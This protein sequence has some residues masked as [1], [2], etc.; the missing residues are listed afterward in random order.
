MVQ[1]ERARA[2]RDWWKGGRVHCSLDQNSLD[3]KIQSNLKFMQRERSESS[4]KKVDHWLYIDLLHLLFFCLHPSSHLSLAYGSSDALIL[5]TVLIPTWFVIWLVVVLRV[6][7]CKCR[8]LVTGHSRAASG[9]HPPLSGPQLDGTLWGQR[10]LRV[11]VGI[12]TRA[13]WIPPL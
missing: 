4:P 5:L 8:V 11:R 13:E 2:K 6:G 7:E 3:L 9:L 10:S 1:G 12:R